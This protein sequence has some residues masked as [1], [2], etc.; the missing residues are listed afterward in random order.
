MHPINCPV[1][2]SDNLNIFLHIQD[3]PLYCN[4]LYKSRD[5]AQ[6]VRRAGIQ[7]GFCHCCGHVYNYAF[8]PG[9][10][11]YTLDYE[12]SL[13]FSPQFHAYAQ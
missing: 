2:L 6:S 3:I 8:D 7:L 5:E 1:C 9:L 12:N 10:M 4:L 13:H 11:D